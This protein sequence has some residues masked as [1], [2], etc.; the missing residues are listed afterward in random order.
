MS[1]TYR[2]LVHNVLGE[3]VFR[4]HEVYYSEGKPVSY[5]QN[6]VSVEGESID[7]VLLVL[8][9]M[10]RCTERPILSAENFPEVWLSE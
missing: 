1:W 3:Q 7:D 8:D 5:T 2:I 6:P 10:K 9:R 4:V